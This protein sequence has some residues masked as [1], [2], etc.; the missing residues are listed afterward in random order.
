MGLIKNLRLCETAD[1]FE[2]LKVDRF[3]SKDVEAVFNNIFSPDVL[4]ACLRYVVEKK[5][6]LDEVK[7]RRVFYVVTDHYR[8]DLIDVFFTEGIIT[9][10]S[11]VN[12]DD[13]RVFISFV[14]Q[15]GS[16]DML[17]FFLEKG[18]DPD[19]IGFWDQSLLYE[20]CF[21]G[22]ID[23]V[24]LLLEKG[25]NVNLENNDGCVALFGAIRSPDVRILDCLIMAGAN[26]HHQDLDGNTAWNYVDWT[27]YRGRELEDIY[28]RLVDFE[29]SVGRRN[30][31]RIE[32]AVRHVPE[33]QLLLSR[34]QEVVDKKGFLDD[35]RE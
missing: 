20:A 10:E 4:R 27:N 23:L 32:Y 7:I 30:H 31:H 8:I 25:A 16:V 22:K 15:E 35:S 24:R 17:K 2:V 6:P 3:F 5:G 9:F 1:D 28:Q 18:L 21:F 26:I 33:L 11:L 19:T 13:F 14:I 29:V 34:M 12:T